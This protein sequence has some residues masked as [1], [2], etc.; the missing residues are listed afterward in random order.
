MTIP[1][2]LDFIDQTKLDLSNLKVSAQLGETSFEGRVQGVT[3]M[4][5][6]DVIN[7]THFTL[8]RLF[9]LTA[10]QYTW[11]REFPGEYQRLR[12]IVEGGSNSTHTVTLFRDPRTVPEPD[13]T[14]PYKMIWYNQSLSSLKDLVFV[15]QP[16]AY[17]LGGIVGKVADAQSLLPIAGAS[18]TT[19]GFTAITD[20][21]GN[22]FITNVPPGSYTVT[23]SA[24][25]Y[26]SDSKTTHIQPGVTATV[27][28]ELQPIAP[29]KGAIQGTVTDINTGNPIADATVSANGNSVTTDMN[30]KYTIPD[31]TPGTYNVEASATEYQS[32]S[33]SVT[34]VAGQTETVDFALAPVPKGT[35]SVT[36]T[37][38]AGEVFVNGISW[39]IAPQSRDVQIGT[40]NVSFG[41]VAGY[42]TPTWQMATVYENLETTVTGVY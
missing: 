29:R 21:N 1:W 27:N 30:G 15:I 7:A 35:L 13:E 23:A 2:Q 25:G 34:V 24:D 8:E 36:T 41:P 40:Y 9:N 16:Q 39:G 20:Q 22:Y 33:K 10:P 32:A 12:I 42:R 5:P 4:P 19:D 38:V 18:V 26:L 17:N 37:P 28:F 3:I 11:Q 31:L 6:R 14:A